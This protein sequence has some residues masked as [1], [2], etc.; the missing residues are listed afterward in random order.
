MFAEAVPHDV[1]V[2]TVVR[3]DEALDRF[4]DALDE[5]S[6]PVPGFDLVVVDAT[7]GGSLPMAERPR[8]FETQVVRVDP[9]VSHGAALNA[10][11]RA[12]R[13]AGIGFLSADVVPNPIW[14]EY[15]VRS[16]RRGRHLVTGHWLPTEQS[17]PNTGALSFR[18]WAPPHDARLV[19]TEQMAC[20]R[21]DLEAVGG[22]DESLDGAA[23]DM[24]LAIRL[25]ESGVD[26]TT[27]RW[28]QCMYDVE[29]VDL[30]AM[31][32][33]RRA[34]ADAVRMLAERP[35]ARARLLAAGVIRR[36]A[37][38]RALLA[39]AGLLLMP[40]DRRAALLVL[41]WYHERTCVAPRAGGPRRKRFVLP[42]VFG[43]DLYDAAIALM[44]RLSDTSRR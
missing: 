38:P 16:L 11:W 7:P 13:G 30:R 9:D 33:A 17:L 43:F 8:R 28:L 12:A 19:S 25:V 32:A 20:R 40:K 14:L 3:G 22:F 2:C 37:Q 18:L 44:A 4:L 10:G 36:G 5:Q 34:G 31:V 15:L 35:G 6:L 21:A 41:P 42:G 24:D 1:T 26:P 23:C 39:L 27:S 29:P